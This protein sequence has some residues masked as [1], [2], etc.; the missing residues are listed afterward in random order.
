MPS[1]GSALQL[2]STCTI[3]RQP[4]DTDSDAGLPTQASVGVTVHCGRKLL[5]VNSCG[6][7]CPNMTR[8][9]IAPDVCTAGCRILHMGPEGVA[10][11][12]L[13]DCV[14]LSEF[15]W[16]GIRHYRCET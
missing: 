3:D 14:P 13:Y 12:D 15:V 11:S 2:I 6:G 10:A 5:S 16:H 9:R 1:S 8:T 4:L 7:V